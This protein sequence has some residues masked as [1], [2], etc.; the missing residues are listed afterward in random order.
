M[1]EKFLKSGVADL[2]EYRVNTHETTGLDLR[3][4]VVKGAKSACV[5]LNASGSLRQ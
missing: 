1:Y 3:F 2:R 4:L 5:V